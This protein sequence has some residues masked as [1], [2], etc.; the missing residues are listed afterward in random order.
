MP[1]I[2]R[3]FRCFLT[4]SLTAFLFLCSNAL[5][6]QTQ[7]SATTEDGKGA[8]ATVHPLATASALEMY[9]QG[10][11][12]VDA[13]IAAA[14]A[15]GVVDGHNSG[16]GGGCFALIR[17]ADGR[18]EAIDGREMAPGAASHDMYVRN[19]EVDTSLSKVGPLAS[20][21][22]GSVAAYEYMSQHGGKLKF[23]QLLAPSVRYAADGF[24]IDSNYASRLARTAPRLKAFAGSA[25]VLLD[26]DGNPWPEGHKLVQS[27]LAK[28]Y[29]AIAD[30][31]SDSFYKGSYAKAVGEW[32]AANGGIITAKDFANYELKT[33]EAVKSEY[34]GYTIY[35]FPPPS[36][37]GVHVAEILN[38]LES[39][40]LTAL[41]EADR[42]H[43]IAEAMKIAFADRAHWLG[44][45]DYV[46]VPRGL[47]DQGYADGLAK[48][49]RV[50]KSTVV[51]E[52]GTPPNND[53]D[54]FGKHTTHIAAA[55][56]EGNWVAITTTVNTGFGSNVIVPG[57][58]VILNNQM[59]D[60]SVQPG[61]PNAFRLVGAEA[62][63]IQPG[64]RPLSSMS[65]TL[66][67]K[68]GK[69]MMTVGAAG[70]PTI[71]TSVV[72][73][74]INR[75]DLNMNLKDAMSAPRVH[76]QWSPDLLF[77]EPEF[78]AEV[79]SALEAKGHNLA[80][81]RLGTAQAIVLD[82]TE[83]FVTQSEPRII[84]ANSP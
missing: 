17:W 49:I 67:L 56:A 72:M 73:A 60:F 3:S 24:P 15:L 41:P 35:G 45:P 21:I 82:K 31:G 75:I 22:P 34:R 78:S 70:G 79:K 38:I 16:I 19:G 71:I 8:I 59:D 32:M 11:N 51:A 9:K 43:V 23:K 27:D 69:P 18:V 46:D 25:A 47:I 68:D 63:S 14:F 26:A 50:D 30:Q 29:Q 65:P 61:T 76:H 84:Q 62:N 66:V 55:D 5:L 40:D 7:Y 81:R 42:V 20:G 80:Q 4:S 6:A 48:K 58:G 10:G 52:Y 2:S 28:T 36:S 13:A 83:G 37:G 39:F 33:R 77:V 74:I 1:D 44:D 57:T 54:I 64:K 53:S 12:A